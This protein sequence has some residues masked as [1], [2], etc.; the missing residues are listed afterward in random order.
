[1]AVVLVGNLHIGFRRAYIFNKGFSF[2]T[3]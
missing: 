1:M 2:F 3:I